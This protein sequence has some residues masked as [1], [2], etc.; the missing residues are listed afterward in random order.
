MACGV[1]DVDA[2][3]VLQ[4]VAINF[5][6]FA[7]GRHAVVVYTGS[8]LRTGGGVCYLRLPIHLLNTHIVQLMKKYATYM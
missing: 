3:A 4:K 6:T 7:R 1:G 5:S 8:K 2:G